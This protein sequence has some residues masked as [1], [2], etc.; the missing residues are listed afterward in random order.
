M[1]KK[2]I[3]KN[4]LCIRVVL[5]G[6]FLRFFVMTKG[7]NFDFE[8]YCIVGKIAGNFGNVYAETYRYNYGP[9][10]FC[11]LGLLYRISAFTNNPTI[12]FRI[13]I[14]SILTLAD[15][16]IM[17]FIAKKYSKKKALIFFL[18]PVSIII[19]GYHLFNYFEISP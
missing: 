12:I 11:V 5:V 3:L 15:L 14:V 10:F 4:S 7:H 18:N 19:T 16:G 8:S 17:G 2:S 13:L 1:N 9:I 6:I